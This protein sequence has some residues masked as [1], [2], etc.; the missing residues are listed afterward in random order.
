M[1]RKRN[2]NK[3]SLKDFIE[4][5]LPGWTQIA[6]F[7]IAIAAGYILVS[8]I[9]NAMPGI[10]EIVEILGLNIELSSK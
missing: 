4:D 1:R 8:I 2:D 7:I 9:A 5:I 10:S 6:L 3:L